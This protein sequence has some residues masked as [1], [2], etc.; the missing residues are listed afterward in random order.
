MN[1]VFF[2]KDYRL[3]EITTVHGYDSE[4]HQLIMS[5]EHYNPNPRV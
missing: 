1:K 4:K 3:R 2:L 5:T